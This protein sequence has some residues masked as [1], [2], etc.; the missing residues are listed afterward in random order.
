MHYDKVRYR[1]VGSGQRGVGASEKDQR[2][3]KTYLGLLRIQ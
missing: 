1:S 3:E 2:D